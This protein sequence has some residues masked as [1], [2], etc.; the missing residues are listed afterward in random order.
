MARAGKLLSTYGD[1]LTDAA[2][3]ASGDCRRVLRDHARRTAEAMGLL[4][5]VGDA[6]PSGDPGEAILAY[7]TAAS[8]LLDAKA[9]RKA[10][11]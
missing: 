6:L 11:R 3:D 7:N 2:D 9:M 8:E 10:C 1:D 5:L 4:A